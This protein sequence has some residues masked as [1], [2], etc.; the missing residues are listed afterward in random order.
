MYENT[1][2]TVS[3]QRYVLRKHTVEVIFTLLADRETQ[4]IRQMQC[5]LCVLLLNRG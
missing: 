3:K 4:R 1:P 2:K 5:H